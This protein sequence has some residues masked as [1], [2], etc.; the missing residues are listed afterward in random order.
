M[1]AHALFRLMQPNFVEYQMSKRS[2][3]CNSLQYLFLCVVLL[4]CTSGEE[5]PV[6][7]NIVFFM[8]DDMGY[9][10]IGA[11]GNTYH[12]TPNIDRMA[13]EGM[14]FTDAYAAAPNCSPTRGSMLTGR[15]P[16]R[17]GITQYLPGNVLPYAQ[18][19]Q[20]DLPKGLSLAHSVIAEPLQAAGYATASIGKWHL[21][22]GQYGPQERGF[23]VA[24]AG[25]HWNA[26]TSMF[27]PH[28]FVDVPD[29]SDG[30][31]L[32]DR[33]TSEALNFIEANKHAPF[34]LYLPYYAIHGPIQA[35]ESLIEGYANRVDESGRNNATYAAMV[36]GVDQSV[37][38]I[39]GHLDALSLSE[40]TIVF[41]YSDNGGVPSRAFNNPFSSG[42]GFLWEGGIRVPLIVKW[43][44]EIQGGLR[45]PV[46]VSSVDFY[47]TML[48]I[49]GVPLPEGYTVDGESLIPV[50]T[51]TGDL[52]RDALFWHYPH[53]SN[54]GATPTGAMRSGDW[55]L[56]EFFEDG[57][58]AL[59]NLADDPGE[60][61]DLSAQFPER[62]SDMAEK[63]AGWRVDVAAKPALANP[64]YDPER[65]SQRRGYRYKPAWDE[66]QPLVNPSPFSN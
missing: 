31:Y 5:K 13:E 59:F 15:W 11:Y 7:Y 25:G 33:L 40:H 12:Q 23:E 26:H 29:A 1:D 8:L 64:H 2:I 28:P 6:R 41:F 16:A 17:T 58:L 22:G 19:L 38:Q 10:D 51:Q 61:T 14:L 48:N 44:G 4:G 35:K 24:F 52:Q 39:L 30:D 32:T 54:A 34:F 36:E 60:S 9:A 45:S 46:P 47:P 18:L 56:I 42:K 27:A 55:K 3:T 62:V 49:A 53:Y 57:R 37:G 50:L 21:G 43:P 63:L 20:P 66:A 65:A